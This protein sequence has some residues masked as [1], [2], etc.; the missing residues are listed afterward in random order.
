[1]EIAEKLKHEIFMNGIEA[2][3][4]FLG[5]EIDPEEDKDTIDSRMNK[6][7]VQMPK[8]DIMAF[9][10]KYCHLNIISARNIQ[11]DADNDVVNNL[12]EEIEIPEGLH[13]C[14]E[15]IDDYLSDQT[16]YCHFGYELV[17]RVCRKC[18]TAVEREVDEELRIEYPYYC[19]KCYENMYSFETDLVSISYEELT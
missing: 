9:Y 11:W 3:E 1:M 16:G 17:K 2:I 12:P 7:L 14:P 10:R 6:V 13:C 18:G 19:L 4:D 8:E 15:K 5:Y